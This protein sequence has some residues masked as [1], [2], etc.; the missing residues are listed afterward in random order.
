MI[1]VTARKTKGLQQQAAY[2]Q[3]ASDQ[4]NDTMPTSSDVLGDAVKDHIVDLNTDLQ[5]TINDEVKID[6]FEQWSKNLQSTPTKTDYDKLT[7]E[8]A[9][10][11]NKLKITIAKYLADSYI[12]PIYSFFKNEELHENNE[13]AGKT[14]LM[15]ENYY[16][17]NDLLYKVSLP[18]RKKRESDHNSINYAYLKVTL[19]P[20]CRN[21][22][23]PLDIFQ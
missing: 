17:E 19:Q 8:I 23:Q 11:I 10:T 21:G 16:I 14:L 12:K 5:Q 20:C 15:S 3:G 2:D 1:T 22:M 6:K 18:R 9:E 4:N 13:K 7:D